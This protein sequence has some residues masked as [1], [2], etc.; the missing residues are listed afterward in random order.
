MRENFAK[1]TKY[2]SLASKE[3][4]EKIISEL[5]SYGT[6]VRVD[7]TD[8]GKLLRPCQKQSFDYEGLFIWIYEGI[9]SYS[10]SKPITIASQ[11]LD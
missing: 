6:F 1:W 10:I 2:D 4:A 8:D 3:A 5:L 11:A 7:K 9:T